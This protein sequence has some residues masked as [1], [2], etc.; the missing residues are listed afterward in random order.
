M[1]VVRE[2]IGTERCV[3]Q[4]CH[5]PRQLAIAPHNPGLLLTDDALQAAGGLDRVRA[6]ANGPARPAEPVF[7]ADDFERADPIAVFGVYA[8]AASTA[9]EEAPAAIPKLVT[10]AAA[11]ADTDVSIVDEELANV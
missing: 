4:V 9:E 11:D 5:C 8:E 10:R 7:M 1:Q 3:E 2:V 6:L